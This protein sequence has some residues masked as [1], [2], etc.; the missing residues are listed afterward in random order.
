LRIGIL[1][2][3]LAVIAPAWA[4][5]RV[6]PANLHPRILA[7]VPIVGSGTWADPKR[8]SFL[9]AGP[10]DS[11]DRAGII[12]FQQILSD[13]GNFALV[14]LVAVDRSA[15]A[16]ILNSTDS[17]VKA[18]EVGKHTRQEIEAVFKQFKAT[19]SFDTFRPLRVQ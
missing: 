3:C 19:F 1:S 15:F 14:E 6:D 7:V 4:Q 11:R 9:P 12:A 8:P 18:F 17:R 10:H 16:E 5:Q 2:V 13:N